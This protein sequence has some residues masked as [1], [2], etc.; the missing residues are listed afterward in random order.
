MEIV[1]LAFRATV[2][3]VA[4]S[5]V[6]ATGWDWLNTSAVLTPDQKALGAVV[7]TV[8]SLWCLVKIST[9]KELT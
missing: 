4:V 3:V 2:A 5:M 8:T 6:S 7:L 9:S 1:R